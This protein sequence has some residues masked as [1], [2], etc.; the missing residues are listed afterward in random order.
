LQW[1]HIS[2]PNSLRAWN[3][4]DFSWSFFPVAP[5]AIF[6]PRPGLNHSHSGVM[7]H[8]CGDMKIIFF[9][10]DRLEVQ[11]VRQELVAAS[12]LCEIREGLVTSDGLPNPPA[13]Q[14]W[15]QEDGDL[16]RAFMLCVEHKIGFAQREIKSPE[17]NDNDMAVAA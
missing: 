11:R 2:F 17:I 13:P 3:V 5:S 1:I 6:Q 16:H 7:F 4:P 12:I 8:T 14:L 15:I 10:R 9:S